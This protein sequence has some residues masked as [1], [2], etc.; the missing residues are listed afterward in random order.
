[1]L[2]LTAGLPTLLVGGAFW[3]AMQHRDPGGAFTGDLQRVAT[4]G[5]ALVVDDVDRL[6]RD[7]APFV[8]VGDT[9]LRLT[10]ESGGAPAFLGI[11]PAADVERYLADVPLVA[12][13][14]IDLGTGALPVTGNLRP[15]TVAPEQLPGRQGFWLKSGTGTL[16][17]NPSELRDTRYSL[18]VM[19]PAGQPGVRLESTASVLPGWLNQ[20]TWALLILGSL[21]VMIGM[22]VLGWPSRRREVVYVVEP[23]Q[24]PDLM[25]AIGAPLPLSRTGGGRHAGTHRPRTLADSQPRSRPAA[26]TWPPSSS[27]NSSSSSSSSSPGTPHAGHGSAIPMPATP[28]SG[29]AAA[30]MTA[31]APAQAGAPSADL[32]AA[33]APAPSGLPGS[34]ASGSEPSGVD[35]SPP[36][37]APGEP[38]NL[39]ANRPAP[40]SVSDP[41]PL[42][43]PL[44]GRPAD[45]QGRRRT[46]QQAADLPIFEASA[47]GAWVAET[48]AARAR[49]RETEARAAAAINAAR[50]P[51][52]NSETPN[53][54]T[55]PVRETPAGSGAAAT[56]QASPAATSAGPGE[57]A[58]SAASAPAAAE[59]SEPGKAK[60]LAGEAVPAPSAAGSV[61]DASRSGSEKT[62]AG[63]AVDASRSGSEKAAVG[64]A[65]DASRSGSEKAAVDASRASSR[66]T[67]VG[68][69]GAGDKP[70]ET[71]ATGSATSQA[72]AA[73]AAAM[74]A[75]AAGAAAARAAASVPGR[76]GAKPAAASVEAASVEAAEPKAA[77]GGA[78]PAAGPGV[79]APGGSAG[80]SA[81]GGASSR[82]AAGDASQHAGAAGEYDGPEPVGPAKAA[83]P[84]DAAPRNALFGGSTAPGWAA[85]GLTRA[86]SARVGLPKSGD[87]AP[88]ASRRVDDKPAAG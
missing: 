78:G 31:P 24:V 57:R 22:I 2:L 46:V 83:R 56:S 20:A 23:S 73:G 30:T 70:A 44:F 74:S 54:P 81:T 9:R 53:T 66:E 7:D 40:G 49:A 75:T 37:T 68:S 48:A 25:Q 32:A 71:A 11:A 26:L 16:A 82:A 33:G 52:A 87:S 38:L 5:Y 65:V 39:I 47:V 80:T 29:A 86:D 77:A 42:H 88:A 76:S 28:V 18:V 72:S 41:S 43:D 62:V 67:V 10:A 21:L 19:N 13:S 55:T 6:L 8:R 15:G 69:A 27:S 14:S 34:S 36:A 51:T 60:A 64:A 61:A 79:R 3:A 4:S 12:V 50:K 45:R 17:W 58:G 35:A 1:M 84:A 85:T 59:A 63:A